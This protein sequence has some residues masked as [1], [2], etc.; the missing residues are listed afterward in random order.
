MPEFPSKSRGV[1]HSF[2]RPHVHPDCVDW[3]LPWSRTLQE[4]MK[5]WTKQRRKQHRCPSLLGLGKFL[6]PAPT[7][8]HRIFSP[9][10]IRRAAALILY[11]YCW[12]LQSCCWCPAASRA[13]LPAEMQ[14]SSPL[15]TFRL[16]FSFS[17]RQLKL[18]ENVVFTYNST[19]CLSKF[20]LQWLYIECY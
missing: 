4:I 1:N 19:N 15:A 16:L 20:S 3:A 8:L 17:E 10:E 7:G 2:C 9:P 14:L 5:T 13:L 11:R 6:S 18:F 12:P